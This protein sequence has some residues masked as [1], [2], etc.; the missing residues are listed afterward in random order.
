[1]VQHRAFRRVAS[2]YDLS[3]EEFPPVREGLDALEALF[4]SRAIFLKA[5]AKRGAHGRSRGYAS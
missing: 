2:A 3:A 5:V 1:A 4:D